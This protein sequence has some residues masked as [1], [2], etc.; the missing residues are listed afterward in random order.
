MTSDTLQHYRNKN[1]VILLHV[2]L[3]LTEV[4]FKKYAKRTTHKITLTSF[5]M[6][7]HQKTRNIVYRWMVKCLE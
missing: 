6:R 1:L 4:H 3:I 7:F 2:F 5:N